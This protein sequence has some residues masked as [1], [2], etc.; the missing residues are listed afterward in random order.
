MGVSDRWAM[1][2]QFSDS[3]STIGFKSLYLQKKEL[4]WGIMILQ[5][6]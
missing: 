2:N 3:E 1:I 6:P 4:A 5:L